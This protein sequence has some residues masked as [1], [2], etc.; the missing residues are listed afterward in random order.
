MAPLRQSQANH[1]K[2][3]VEIRNFVAAAADEL[4]DRLIDRIFVTAGSKEFPEQNGDNLPEGFKH[5]I[6][7]LEVTFVKLFQRAICVISGWEILK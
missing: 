2:L 7:G 3:P 4:R 6:K 5:V 1:E